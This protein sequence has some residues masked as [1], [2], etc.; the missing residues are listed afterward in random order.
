M[1]RGLQGLSTFAPPLVL[2]HGAH[3]WEGLEAEVRASK[4]AKMQWGPGLYLTNNIWTARSYAKGGGQV[5]RF[6]VDPDLG[7]LHRADLPVADMLDFA[8][9]LPRRRKEVE[10]DLLRLATRGE[11]RIP[12]LFAAALVN[13][14]HNRGVLAGDAGL[15]LV[16]FYLSRGIDAALE[17]GR[18]YDGSDDWV[19]LYNMRKVRSW[20][21]LPAAE[22]VEREP[23]SVILGATRR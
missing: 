23:R 15:Q 3:R 18:G 22:Q 21:R 11:E 5:L 8:R 9:T 4:T 20:R 13:S 16:R 7:W 6:E 1:S 2:F 12:T 17:K 19:L 10:A 14:M